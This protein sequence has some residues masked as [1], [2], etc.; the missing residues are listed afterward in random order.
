MEWKLV[1][2]PGIANERPRLLHRRLRDQSVCRREFHQRRRGAGERRCPMERQLLV[3]PGFGDDVRMSS[4]T[5]GDLVF[6]RLFRLSGPGNRE[7]RRSYKWSPRFSALRAFD[8]RL[9]LGTEL[10]ASLR[11]VHAERVQSIAAEFF[12]EM[13]WKPQDDFAPFTI[14]FIQ[15][16]VLP[17]VR[18]DFCISIRCQSKSAVSG[19][20]QPLNTRRNVVNGLNW[21]PSDRGVDNLALKQRISAASCSYPLLRFILHVISTNLV[22]SADFSIPFTSAK[23][24]CKRLSIG[25]CVAKW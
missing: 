25:E 20:S 21:P 6:A 3:G 15:T 7:S 23:R 12:R 11:E 4:R 18:W 19:C 2:R 8:Y 10:R 13:L 16:C 22:N 9:S 14:L 1:V 24:S 17:E 5:S